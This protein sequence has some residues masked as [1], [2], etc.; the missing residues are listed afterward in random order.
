[1]A[2]VD[3]LG[4]NL[5]FVFDKATVALAIDFH[6]QFPLSQIRVT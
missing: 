4:I 3:A 6:R 1:M 5:S 2:D